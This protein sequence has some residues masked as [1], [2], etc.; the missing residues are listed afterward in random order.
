MIYVNAKF[1]TKII[2]GVERY[3]TEISYALKKIDPSILFLVPNY[4]GEKNFVSGL[5]IKYITPFKEYLWEQLT[6]PFYLKKKR[7]PLLI[8]LTNTAPIFY[9]NQILVIHDLAFLHEPNWYTKRAAFSFKLLVSQSI[10]ASKKIIT[11]S[12]FTKQEVIKYFK[13][14]SEMIEVI[15]GAIPS[16]ISQYEE[17]NFENKYGKYILTVSSIEPRKNILNLVTAFLRLNDPNI[18]LIVV[19]KS[20]QRVFNTVNYDFTQN[21]NI[22]L[23]G[24]I[25]DEELVGLYKNARLF[26]YLS[27]YEG[28]GFP[29]LE[30]ISCGCPTLVSN[31]SSLPE[32]CGDLAEYC[33]P[34]DIDSITSKIELILNRNKKN[35]KESIELLKQK[36]D[37]QRSAKMILDL[38]HD[39]R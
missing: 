1:L 29:P 17:K 12:N 39:I 21:K 18:K 23:T 13:I 19:G 4:N 5:N 20:N 2:T 34:D 31:T 3:A 25:S 7:N 27:Y 16:Y 11:V 24:Y 10:K 22:I 26:A 9:K 30:A 15:P 36:F 35:N 32:V 37:W 8:N 28:F 38:I 6:L 33:N 14:P